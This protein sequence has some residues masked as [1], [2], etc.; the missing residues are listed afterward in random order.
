MNFEWH[1]R[2]KLKKG[3]EGMKLALNLMKMS[4][5]MALLFSAC[6]DGPCPRAASLRL[7]GDAA[8]KLELV[9]Q[10]FKDLFNGK[11]PN[12]GINPDETDAYG[13]N[14]RDGYLWRARCCASSL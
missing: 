5:L 14:R 3:P 4:L 12:R 11:E 10:L 6:F 9:Q 2:D 13:G 1:P 7:Y 8:A